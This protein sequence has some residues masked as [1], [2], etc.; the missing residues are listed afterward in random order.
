MDSYKKYLPEGV[1]DYLPQECYNKRQL[2]SV[3]RNRFFI[4]GYDEVETPNFEY[5]DVFASGIGSVRQEKMLKFIDS[6]GRIMVLRPDITMPIARMAAAR[7]KK[8]KPPYRLFYIGNAYGYEPA[9]SMQQREF[10]QAGIE[11]IGVPGPEADAEVIALA[12]EAV[13]DAGLKGF[14][15]EIGQ[16]DFFKG[17]ME[18]CDLPFEKIEE[19]RGHIDHKNCLE[20]ELFLGACG[21]DGGVR[22]KLMKLPSL[23]GGAEVLEQALRLSHSKRSEAAVENIR[24]IYTALCRYG[25]EKYISIDFS[26]L[27]S[28]DYYSGAIFR[29]I[30]KDLGY[31]ILT[32]GRY[33][34]LLGEFG[35][36]LPATGFA[37]G[38]KRVMIALERQGALQSIP[39]PQTVVSC[40]ENG[41]ELA[42]KAF[43][44]MRKSGRRTELALWIKN[45]RDLKRYA[46]ERGVQCWLFINAEGNMEG[47][48]QI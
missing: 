32:G 35:L 29:G 9:H 33:D 2:E 28:I 4:S 11:L 41:V 38:I 36:A 8:Q 6:T 25:Y 46:A 23:Y 21:L 34:G 37:L 10:T 26:M 19:L 40:A 24:A 22:E 14:Q 7:L 45:T 18:E 42:Y 31:P 17:L 30:T 39:Q 47:N 13:E 12:I 15:I 16:V 44:E 43:S 5:F 48:E 3:I 20:V 27:Q 1:Q